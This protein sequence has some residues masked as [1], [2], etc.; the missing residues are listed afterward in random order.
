MKILKKPV[1]AIIE[2]P[3]CNCEFEIRGKDWRK[4]ERSRYDNLN[5]YV[6]RCPNC[7]H[8]KQIIPAEVKCKK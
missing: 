7:T 3:L 6:A 5:N 2:C 8:P 1:R 4:I